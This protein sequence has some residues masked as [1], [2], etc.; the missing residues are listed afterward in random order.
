MYKLGVP[1]LA[2]TYALNPANPNTPPVSLILK[3]P[4]SLCEITILLLASTLATM[5]VN[6][7]ELIA[8]AITSASLEA[9]VVVTLIVFAP[10]MP[11][12]LLMF[13]VC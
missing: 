12:C 9:P 6:P 8:P 10:V 2:S 7:A 4:P 11:H 3:S 13:L 5:L 1:E